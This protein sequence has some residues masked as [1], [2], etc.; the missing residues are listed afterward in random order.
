[1][2]W[3][4]WSP[5]L[6]GSFCFFEPENISGLFLYRFSLYLQHSFP[7]VQFC[8]GSP[9]PD[10]FS[11]LR[12]TPI[13]REAVSGHS[14][15]FWKRLHFFFFLDCH[16]TFLAF[17]ASWLTSPSDCELQGLVCPARWCTPRAPIRELV[18]NSCLLS[19]ASSSSQHLCRVNITI[20][21]ILDE[22]T[23][24]SRSCMKLVNHVARQG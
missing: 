21:N 15:L 14:H 12:A 23:E 20:F 9:S 16:D 3:D 7:L 8:P 17:P 11:G 5:W 6:S 24:A 19:G 1:M 10:I 4:F 22:Q 2:T 18:L 13:R